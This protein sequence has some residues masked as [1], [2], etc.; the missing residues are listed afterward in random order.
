MSTEREV[1]I[2]RE[3]FDTY[4]E[5]VA[6]SFMCGEVP[7]SVFAIHSRGTKDNDWLATVK[8][9]NSLT[10][11]MFRCE[12]YLEDLLRLCRRCKFWLI[13]EPALKVV[14][15]YFML[16][17]LLQTQNMNF[18]KSATVGYESMLAGA[19]DMTYRFISKCFA[20]TDPVQKHCLE[21]LKCHN[22]L[23]VNLPYGQNKADVKE[24][25]EYEWCCYKQCMLEKYPAA[26]RKS[27]HFKASGNIMDEQR[28]VGS[29][30]HTR[31]EKVEDVLK[32][33]GDTRRKGK[34]AFSITPERKK[35]SKWRLIRW[36]KMV[37]TGSTTNRSNEVIT[38]GKKK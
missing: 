17:P 19:G 33:K 34:K 6:A 15:L 16:H 29:L 13:T 28:P 36:M 37:S 11:S 9:K 27:T 5:F 14:S 20:F 35:I 31:K 23:A 3:M 18:A 1:E 8:F 32:M 10:I 30:E 4:V 22:I 2:I 21:V 12:V 26:Y 25:M 24:L 7:S 38:N